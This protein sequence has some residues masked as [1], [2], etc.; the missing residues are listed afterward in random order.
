M[1]GMRRRIPPSEPIFCTWCSCSKKSSRVKRPDMQPVGRAGHDVLVH[2]PLG[3]LDQREHV[4]HAEDPVGHAVRVEQVEVAE[5]LPRRRED[6]RA[7]HHLL[8][9][10]RGAAAGVAVELGED[11]AVEGQ[12]LV[13]GP[14]GGHRVLAGHRVDDEER[15]VRIGPLPRSGAPRP[16]SASSMVRRP[17]VSMMQTSRPEPAG[18]LDAR[19]P[20]STPG[21][22]AG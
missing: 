1:P 14:G 3:L 6:D 17:A 18:L 5:L 4:A 19:P 15:V 10:E 12:R 11:H 20:R 22:R 9:T 16:S 8:H 13:E 2:G 7:A 21:R